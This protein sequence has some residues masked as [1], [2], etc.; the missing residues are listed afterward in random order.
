MKRL[1]LLCTSL[2]LLHLY[3]AARIWRVNNNAGF[4]ADF[5]TL[6]AAIS[7]ASVLPGDT[8]HVEPSATAYAFININKRLLFFGVGYLLDPGNGTTPGNAGL[9]VS[10]LG[11]IIN[12]VAMAAGSEGSRFQGL[13]FNSTISFGSLTNVN[14]V[15]EK[16]YFLSSV[17]PGSGNYSNVTFRKCFFDNGTRIEQTSGTMS[18]F[19][20]ENSIF[21]GGQSQTNLPT[22]TGSNNIIRNN[23]FRDVIFGFSVANAYFANNI[24]GSSAAITFANCVVKNNVF[25]L[26]AASQL[27]PGTAVGDQ[28]NIG[29]GSVY[30]G[31]GSWDG[32]FQLRIPNVGNPAP[33]PAIGAGVTIAG[34][35]PDCGAY[36]AT[37]PY[38]LS[39]IPN[40]PSIYTLIVPVSIP[41]GTN[42]MN[43]TVSTRNNN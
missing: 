38:K 41:A 31:T 39:G 15:F 24:V 13:I 21:L 35:T 29:M 42:S 5:S 26:S 30:L 25:Q 9:H 37:D 19:T 4:S 6:T 36:G 8:V 34:F 40:I 32:R 28:F 1:V 18:N 2:L 33:N 14:V 12:G 27:V 23:S 16:C 10:T 11:A 22:L 3:A 43:V 7:S 17:F 20:C